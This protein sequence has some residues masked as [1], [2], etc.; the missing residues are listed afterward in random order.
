MLEL[1]YY[2][3]KHVVSQFFALGTVVSCEID[4]WCHKVRMKCLI[5]SKRR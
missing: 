4:S 3:L 2:S 5:D 1:I